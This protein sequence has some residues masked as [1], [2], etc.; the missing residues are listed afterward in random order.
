MPD[1]TGQLGA[2]ILASVLA[3]VAAVL[4]M[5]VIDLATLPGWV[6]QEFEWRS[7]WR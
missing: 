7:R 4:F 6:N 1:L 5:G 2:R 3:L